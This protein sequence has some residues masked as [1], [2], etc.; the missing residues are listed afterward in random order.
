M[1]TALVV[2][3]LV[4]ARMMSG[5]TVGFMSLD[6]LNLQIVL[7]EGSAAEKRYAARVIPLLKN[8]NLLLVTLVLTNSAAAQTCVVVL[9][10]LAA[11]VWVNR[12]VDTAHGV[13]DLN[14]CMRWQAPHLL[15]LGCPSKML[16]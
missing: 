7:R 2:P 5:L 8:H 14:V 16:M 6:P 9:A 11:Y 15:R 12:Q 4:L 1:A 10:L 3:V 13:C